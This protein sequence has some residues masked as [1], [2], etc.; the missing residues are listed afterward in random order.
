MKE[1]N[2]EVLKESA[3][4][5]EELTQLRGGQVLSQ[6]KRMANDPKLL[7]A[8]IDQYKA[9]NSSENK[10]PAKYRELMTMGMGAVRGMETTVRVHG[11]K[12]IEEGATAEEI[13][14]V[15]RAVFM[16]A[17]VSGLF[18]IGAIFDEADI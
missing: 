14:E 9:N 12:A 1:N 6:H 11:Q 4:L 3:H 7:Q 8:F 15:F 16:L 13:G 2:K 10:I 18:Y 5:L 17:G